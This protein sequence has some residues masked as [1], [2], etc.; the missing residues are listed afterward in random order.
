[1]KTKFAVSETVHQELLSFFESHDIHVFTNDLR[2]LFIDYLDYELRI[3]V[4][5]YFDGFLYPF[6]EL[7]DLL[8]KVAEEKQSCCDNAELI[9]PQTVVNGSTIKEKIIA[10]L[11]ASLSPE[12]IFFTA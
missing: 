11:K 9:P 5:L 4:P 8:D 12:K 6:N 3:A 1:M 7:L 10:F 2:R